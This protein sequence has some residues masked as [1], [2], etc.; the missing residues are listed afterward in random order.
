MNFAELHNGTLSASPLPLPSAD[1]VLSP[2]PKITTTGDLLAR[3]AEE[4]ARSLPI[5]RSTCALLAT[6]LGELAD[7]I[8]LDKIDLARRGFRAF[9][10]SRKY[11]KNSVHTYIY[12]MGEILRQARALGWIPTRL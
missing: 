10:L 4:G 12:Q 6:Y 1:F 9:L 7:E 11:K 8:P 3:L 2:A 5:K